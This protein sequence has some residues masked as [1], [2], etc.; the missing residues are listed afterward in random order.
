MKKITIFTILLAAAFN[1]AAQDAYYYSGSEKIP[2]TKVPDKKVI[3]SLKSENA[4]SMAVSPSDLI[5]EDTAFNIILTE[6][7]N[8]YEQIAQS[9]NVLAQDICYID[10]SGLEL[11][12]NGYYLVLLKDAEDYPI[13]VEVATQNGLEVIYQNRYMP[14]WYTLRIK[15]KIKGS[16]VSVANRMFETGIF[17]SCSPS[18]S[19][20]AEELSYDPEVNQQWGLF[21]DSIP[22]ADVCVSEAWSFATGRG[23]KIAIIDSGAD[24]DHQDLEDNIL[25]SYDFHA[26]TMPA[27][28][29]TN[30][31]TYCAGI[32]AAKRNNGLNIS[33]V[34]PDAKLMIAAIQTEINNTLYKQEVAEAINWAW[35]NGADII[36]FS[37]KCDNDTIITQ[38]IDEAMS[39]GRNGKG[40]IFVKSAGNN[41]T[42]TFPGT[43][44]SDIIVVGAIESSGAIW[45]NSGVGSNMFI[46]APGKDVLSLSPDNQMML[47]TG[48]SAACPHVSGVIALMLE[49]NPNLTINQVRQILAETAVKVGNTSY[50]IQ[51]EYGFRNDSYGYGLVNAHQAVI[52]TPRE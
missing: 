47:G 2:L 26:D 30:H 27:T 28:C 6:N 18:F 19:Y 8:R 34:A 48:T 39:R 51:G 11:V 25:M 50:D 46:S 13:L 15:S 5:I 9:E 14:L 43:Y 36:S 1:L 10:D 52:N 16:I 3:I 24:L 33:G 44:R 29:Y 45:G 12:P 37:L 17:D 49:R 42:I 32:A 4:R 20:D 41:G 7:S 35:Q 21:N 23:I 31:G 38:A 40:C 22:D